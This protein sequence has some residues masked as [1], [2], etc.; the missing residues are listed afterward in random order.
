VPVLGEQLL[1]FIAP[2]ADYVLEVLHPFTIIE[3][4]VTSFGGQSPGKLG[5]SG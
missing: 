3:V 4:T 5:H 2:I 1:E